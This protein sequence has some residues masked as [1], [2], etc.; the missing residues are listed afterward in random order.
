MT[1]AILEVESMN[2]DTPHLVSTGTALAM[3]HFLTDIDAQEVVE[4]F[5]E[6][7]ATARELDTLI[8]QVQDTGRLGSRS[9]RAKFK[10]GKRRE[11]SFGG[12]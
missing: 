8:E 10:P 7:E 11:I 3:D 1:F 9:S 4:N 5:A 12:R 6:M 2:F